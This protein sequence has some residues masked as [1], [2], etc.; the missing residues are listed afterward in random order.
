MDKISSYETLF[1]VD[2][3]QGDDSVKA[4]VDKF[5]G[6]IAAMKKY[7]II[8]GVKAILEYLGFEVGAAASPQ[9]HFSDEEKKNYIDMLIST[10]LFD[11]VR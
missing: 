9:K 2:V 1:I 4:L 8:P 6:L 5:T 7:P 10:G 11:I 3:Q